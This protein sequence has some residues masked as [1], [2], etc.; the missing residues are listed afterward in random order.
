MRVKKGSILIVDDSATNVAILN[1]I[2]SERNEYEL[3]T[4]ES[5]E[6][7][8]RQAKRHLPDLV[9]LDIVIPD[10]DGYEVARRLQ[11]DERTRNAAIIFITSLNDP[12]D[13]AKA[14]QVGGIDYI[15]KPF[16]HLEVLSRVD[17][18]IRLRRQY[19]HIA[20]LRGEIAEEL[21]LAQKIQKSIMPR[22]SFSFPPL[23]A[24]C[25]YL[26]YSSIG[27]DFF[28]VID[29]GGG[30]TMSIVVDVTGHGIPAALYTMLLKASLLHSSRDITSAAEYM[31]L[32]N[33]DLCHTMEEGFYPSAVALLADT[34]SMRLSYVNAAHPYPLYQPYGGKPRFLQVTNT[35]LGVSP[36]TVYEEETLPLSPGDRFLVYTDGLL[37]IPCRDGAVTD[38]DT[39]RFEAEHCGAPSLEA[40]MA[41]LAERIKAYSP[42]GRF[43]D[44]VTL[45]GFE[46]SRSG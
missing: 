30:R 32:L 34:G 42:E 20:E 25:T 27:G 26:P 16:N 22:R 7:A 40:R 2:L 12:E 28:D 45:L 8:L 38:V 15:T 39:V 19:E 6:E 33:R 46:I 1:A 21:V 10:L 41:Q 31:G 5:G 24:A 23:Q 11:A 9:L 3:L 18:H 44:D 13:K 29:L 35:I 36:D 37:G 43:E 17:A 14:F 4:A